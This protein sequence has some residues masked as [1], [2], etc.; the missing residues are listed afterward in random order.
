MYGQCECYQ[1]QA[2]KPSPLLAALTAACSNGTR[3][4]ACR[5]ALVKPTRAH[6]SKQPAHNGQTNLYIGQ[7]NTYVLAR[8]LRVDTGAVAVERGRRPQRHAA[9]AAA[10]VTTVT[11]AALVTAYQ[12]DR[13]GIP[14]R[15]R[16]RVLPT[17]AAWPAPLFPQS[18]PQSGGT[19][20]RH[21]DS[22]YA[23]LRT[24]GSGCEEREREEQ[25][26]L[27]TAAADASMARL[28]TGGSRQL[29]S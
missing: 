9:T 7:T 19:H 11:A 29:S 22:E 14:I 12:G 2:G 4:F 3:V 18:S 20:S 5:R 24:G 6:W 23:R 15:R 10:L 17:T 21:G 26:R 13:F 27:R 28:G 8:P 1:Q 16:F 25:M